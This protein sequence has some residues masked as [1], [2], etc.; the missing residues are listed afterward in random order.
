M[1]C[2]N[3]AALNQISRLT[4]KRVTVPPG[5]L[6]TY[7]DEDGKRHVHDHTIYKTLYQCS[8]GHTYVVESLSRCPQPGCLHGREPQVIC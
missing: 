1:R 4:E 8:N 2:R 7:Y 5:D 6:E 3:C